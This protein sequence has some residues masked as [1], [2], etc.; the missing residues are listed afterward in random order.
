MKLLTELRRELL[1]PGSFHMIALCLLGVGLF[2]W[3][4]AIR[5]VSLFLAWL[6]P[7]LLTP[8]AALRA[9][10]DR[11]RGL[12]EVQATAPLR[13][14]TVFL[15]KAISLFLI[16]LTVIAGAGLLVSLLVS[17]AVSDV[18]LQIQGLLLWGLLAGIASLSAG[19]FVGYV[20]MGRPVWGISVSACLALVWL[21]TAI[22]IADGTVLHKAELVQWI[23]L[24]GPL[25]WMPVEIQAARAAPLSLSN[26]NLLAVLLLGAVYFGVSGWV[27]TRH[28]RLANWREGT[29]P[30]RG[31]MALLLA[32][33]LLAVPA[34]IGALPSQEPQRRA[35][36][37]LEIAKGD[38][39][40]QV[41]LVP[42]EE[43]KPFLI[44]A[45]K[46]EAR[47]RLD[48]MG[49]PN[50]T[51]RVDQPSLDAPGMSFEVEE[52]F[53]KTYRLDRIQEDP[54]EPGRKRGSTH[55]YIPITGRT[56]FIDNAGGVRVTV[57]VEGEVLAFVVAGPKDWAYR[58]PL[59]A[60][61]GG[62]LSLGVA[63]AGRGYTRGLNR[64]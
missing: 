58:K 40:V 59:S 14:R 8:L 29:G 34:A 53:P 64:W 61:M 28:Q 3:G 57:V 18:W 47:V 45:E 46:F 38:L 5:G 37:N 4:G 10:E 36:Y 17:G 11:K 62:I 1:R 31:L 51:V 23:A 39:L 55:D 41:G 32:L 2:A 25:A 12:A 6:S 24:S 48:I 33:S 54:E 60:A 43:D 50:E 13:E 15:A 16:W 22:A 35:E 7:L 9:T 49:P 21:A 19:L 56:S 27:A 63:F 44:A 30:W 52:E 26:M 20:S 42:E